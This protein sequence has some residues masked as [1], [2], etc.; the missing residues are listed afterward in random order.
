VE[1][2]LRLLWVRSLTLYRLAQIA[3]K[4]HPTLTNN[5]STSKKHQARAWYQ[6]LIARCH[7]KLAQ[8]VRL[9]L[10]ARAAIVTVLHLY[11]IWTETA[12]FLSVL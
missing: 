8:A 11:D 4:Y 2:C 6:G 1:K 3:L 12:A 9:Q 10:S 5:F 7:A